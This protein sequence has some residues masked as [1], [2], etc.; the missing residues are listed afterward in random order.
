M[1]YRWKADV[2]AA[3][4]MPIQVGT[5]DKWQIIE[6]TTTWKTMKTTLT[7]G[8][9]RGRDGLVLRQRAQRDTLTLAK[10]HSNVEVMKAMKN[11]K[12]SKGETSWPG[13]HRGFPS[14]SFM[15]FMSC[16]TFTLPWLLA[17]EQGTRY[18]SSVDVVEV[19]VTA[20]DGDK[21]LV[22]DL[23][24]DDFE[25]FD[26]GKRVPISVFSSELQPITIGLLLDRS[27]SVGAKMGDVSAAAEAF[28]VKLNAEDR[29]GVSSLTWDCA[30]YT[31]DKA[32]LVATLRGDMPGDMGS[33]IWQGLNR[34]LSALA[35]QPGRRAVLLFSDGDDY[36][37]VPMP[38][39]A[40]QTKSLCRFAVDPGLVTREDVGRRAE[41]E[42]VMV[43]A[44]SV[45]GAGGR[46]NDAEL[47]AVSRATGAERYKLANPAEL[48]AAFERIADELH[49]QYLL[50]FTPE[51]F[52]G[53]R[54]DLDIRVKRSGVTVRGRQSYVAERA[55]RP[56]ASAPPAAIAPLSDEDVDR[57]IA[58][59][60][61]GQRLQASCN[62]GGAFPRNPDEAGALAEVVAEGPAGRVMRLA[63]EA[64]QRREPF[65]RADVT[66]SLRAPVLYVSA[67]LKTPVAPPRP[68]VDDVS[69]PPTTGT[70]PPAGG[71]TPPPPASPFP[72][73]APSRPLGPLQ[74]IQLRSKELTG[75]I[76]EVLA[77][78][79]AP[80]SLRPP[81][82]LG[83]RRLAA[84]FDFSAFKA[85]PGGD[86]EVTV[87]SPGGFRRCT[88]SARDKA[89][90]K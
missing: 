43:Y 64:R 68:P 45:E 78:P 49:H 83:A 47:R 12:T 2:E 80:L 81:P 85:L 15:A 51:S 48:T 74:S 38:P 34:A 55:V 71:L 54:H 73:A 70:P 40:P 84:M 6:P 46:S 88:I 31:S 25:L 1:D 32:R 24:K 77:P 17:A 21:R 72:A 57:A 63:R 5:K 56:G 27:G 8:H 89:A 28:V 79:P 59:G 44:V 41:R 11:M 75:S 30:P 52:D 26:N 42:G 60:L 36:G 23:T 67:E 50:G 58:A 65:T 14:A 22:T 53:K 18:R 33:P 39:M 90:L 86:V 10:S 19:H 20:R 66:N 7:E 62:A 3:F 35:T 87:Q 9:V 61:D 76:L 37:A 13:G 82:G 29:A 4:A 69:A 16:M